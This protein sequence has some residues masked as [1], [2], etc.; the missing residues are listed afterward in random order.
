[1]SKRR[2]KYNNMTAQS[3]KKNWDRESSRKKDK[4]K[5]KKKRIKY[6]DTKGFWEFG[7]E[8]KE[9]KTD[10][11]SVLKKKLSGKKPFDPRKIDSMIDVDNNL[12]QTRS[13]L[14]GEKIKRINTLTVEETKY[15]EDL[16]NIQKSILQL[17]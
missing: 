14:T 10:E 15:G 13:S 2:S 8:Q 12:N 6:K 5:K 17:L 3:L 16:L 7:F 4:K 9:D 11:E 1:M